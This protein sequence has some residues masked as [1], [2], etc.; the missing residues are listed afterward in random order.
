MERSVY[1]RT[2]RD[3]F[4]CPCDETRIYERFLLPDHAKGMWVWMNGETEP[5][6]DLVCAFSANNFGHQHPAL[7]EA[8]ASALH[9]VAVV[10]SFNTAAKLELSEFLVTHLSAEGGYRVYFD[11]GGASAVSAALRLA[12]RHR[13]SDIVVAFDGAF[14]GT[15]YDSAGVSDDRL[16]DKQQYGGQARVGQILRLPYPNT[17]RGVT[18]T[19]VLARL[20]AVLTECRVAAVIVEPV[21]GAAGF[22]VPPPEF[23]PG[24]RAITA[25]HGVILVDDDIQMGVG[26]AGYLYAMEHWNVQPDIALLSKSLAGGFYPLSAVIARADLFDG[27][28]AIG[29]AFQSTFANNA[30]GTAI[31][32]QTLRFAQRERVFEGARVR[33]RELLSRLAFLEDHPQI[34]NL[35]GL[36][37]ALAFECVESKETRTPAPALARRFVDIALEERVLL[38]PCGVDRNVIKLAPM[39]TVSEVDIDVICDRLRLCCQRL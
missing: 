7:V 29:T 19:Q 23:L 36:G 24:V 37:L 22:V 31:A 21:Q 26:R 15:S 16:L 27:V 33:G 14:H 3:A 10:H 8:A 39:L 17:Y 35:H 6:L 18:A 30:L 2:L 20:E 38:Y 28:P 13:S 1:L 25:T 4:A 11:V 32:L 9:Q 5:Y 12:R 34:D